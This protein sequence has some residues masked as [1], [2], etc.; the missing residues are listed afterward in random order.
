MD[1]EILAIITEFEHHIYA[2]PL[3]SSSAHT[4]KALQQK[5]AALNHH[6]SGE[7]FPKTPAF[8][9]SDPA[10]PPRSIPTPSLFPHPRVPLLTTVRVPPHL[11]IMFTHLIQE[12]D[13]LVLRSRV[14]LALVR[15]KP[16][17]PLAFVD[18]ITTWP[19][20]FTSGT[21]EDLALV[22]L[23]TGYEFPGI[24]TLVR[25]CLILSTLIFNP[26]SVDPFVT[27]FSTA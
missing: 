25:H 20:L 19:S 13:P 6:I 17:L 10:F 1:D 3:L 27:A 15:D 14:V 16:V 9:I 23:F 2:L 8:L 4:R 5:L 21:L 18:L 24:E 11:F 12:P 22:R 26:P 7:A